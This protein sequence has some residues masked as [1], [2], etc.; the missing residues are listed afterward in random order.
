MNKSRQW[1][2]YPDKWGLGCD[3]DWSQ[4]LIGIEYKKRPHRVCFCLLFFVWWI[5][6]PR[7][8]H[9]ASKMEEYSSRPIPADPTSVPI[10][11]R[12]DDLSGVSSLLKRVEDEQEGGRESSMSDGVCENCGLIEIPKDSLGLKIFNIRL[13]LNPMRHYFICD[14]GKKVYLESGAKETELKRIDDVLREDIRERVEAMSPE[15]KRKYANKTVNEEWFRNVLTTPNSL[16]LSATA[17]REPDEEKSLR[18]LKL[19]EDPEDG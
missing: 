14:C 6:I 3:W 12:N 2:K 13:E 9:P 4:F 7:K 11:R 17:S 1:H 16:G 18:S 8:E 15:S 5:D 19:K 10:I